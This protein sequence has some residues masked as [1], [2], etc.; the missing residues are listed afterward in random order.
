M[1]TASDVVW[2]RFSFDRSE[3]TTTFMT[4]A[5]VSGGMGAGLM[6]GVCWL[7]FHRVMPGYALAAAAATV[8]LFF[9]NLHLLMAVAFVGAAA[10]VAITDLPLPFGGSTA[11]TIALGAALAMDQQGWRAR[12]ATVAF[13]WLAGLWA[14]AVAS[15]LSARHLG[16]ARLAGALVPL[17]FGLFLG[18]GAWLARV[19]VSAD[20][21]ELRLPP[22]PVHHAWVRLRAALKKLPVGEERASLTKTAADAAQALLVAHRE[23]TA[24]EAGLSEAGEQQAIDAITTLTARRDEATDEQLKAHYEATLRTQRDILEQVAGVKRRVER[25]A[26]KVS[27]EL[28][29]LETAALSVELAPRDKAGL[30][31]LAGRLVSLRR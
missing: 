12:T 31:S 30:Q 5:L 29:W 19:R 1:T 25:A 4:R 7:L 17:A 22:G 24:L 21:L 11:F 14:L 2:G 27:A 6:M 28:G 23:Q 8:L 9:T 15:A 18:I 13:T 26:A 20:R 10:G 3:S 16:T